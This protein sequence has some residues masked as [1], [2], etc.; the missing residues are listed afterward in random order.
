MRL[1]LL[2]GMD[3]TGDLFADFVTEVSARLP[4][5]VINYPP[6]RP[7]TYEGLVEHVMAQLPTQD[8]FILLGE[9]FAGPIAIAIAKRA[10]PNMVGL[11]LCATFAKKPRPLI[12]RAG[13][14]CSG[15][16]LYGARSSLTWRFVLGKFFNPALFAS[17][18]NAIGRVD[19]S[20]MVVRAQ[21]LGKVDVSNDLAAVKVPVLYLKALS[22][23]LVL[24]KSCEHIVSCNPG[25]KVREIDAPHF[26]LQAVPQVAAVEILGFCE[27]FS[28]D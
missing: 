22:D 10:P 24:P 8:P 5:Q 25:V 21:E 1:V 27:Q 2:P 3:G 15:L 9:S 20:V 16:A 19:A 11:V 26:V 13:A 28:R 23:R 4:T 17:I 14:L 6:D 12:A 7:L 18:R